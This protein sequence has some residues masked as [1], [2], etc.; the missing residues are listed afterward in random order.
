MF[1]RLITIACLLFIFIACSS[2]EYR[3]NDDWIPEG[4]S[5]NKLDSSTYEVSFQTYRN[6]YQFVHLKYYALKRAA[7]ISLNNGKDFFLVIDEKNKQNKEVV[8]VPAQK[9]MSIMK[10]DPESQ[11]TQVETIIPA[12]NKDYT[13]K[14]ILL[15]IKILDEFQEGAKKAEDYL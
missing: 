2:L 14:T 5:D 6:D 13:I 15:T 4:Y 9:S 1:F 8:T 7:E 10:T 11:P 12:Y 3:S